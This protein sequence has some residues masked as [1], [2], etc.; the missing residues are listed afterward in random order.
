MK[1]LQRRRGEGG[2]EGFTLIELMVV[3]LIIA[4]LIAIAIPTFLGAQNRSRD[5]SAQSN[6]RNA[7][8]AAKTIATDRD[9]FFLK[10]ATNP[11]DAATLSGVE[12]GLSF[13][14][15]AVST[16]G[17]IGVVTAAGGA[18]I[19]LYNKSGSGSFFCISSTS[20]GVVTYKKGSAASDVNTAALCNGTAW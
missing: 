20:N 1:Y 19:T 15:T 4:I 9:G 7:L 17:P 2:E 18:N 16:T 14:D 13:S 8:T 11:I 6:L 3:V 12:P 5:R 10:D